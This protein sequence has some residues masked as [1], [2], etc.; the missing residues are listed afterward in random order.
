MPQS[1]G[2]FQRTAYLLGRQNPPRFPAIE[3]DWQGNPPHRRSKSG[4]FARVGFSDI[5][6]EPLSLRVKQCT[7]TLFGV[8]VYLAMAC[9]YK[10][11]GTG[12][13]FAE[14]SDAGEEVNVSYG[15]KNHSL[16]VSYF[17]VFFCTGTTSWKYALNSLDTAA[18]G[19]RGRDKGERGR[20]GALWASHRGI[21][22]AWALSYART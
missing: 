15:V 22:P 7:V 9:A 3:K 21:I 4:H 18:L 19:T 6:T 20:T 8:F 17:A 10:T 13:S 16:S 1:A 2:Q 11:S 5:F 14:P 12:K